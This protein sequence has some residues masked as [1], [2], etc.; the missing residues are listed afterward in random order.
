MVDRLQR[1]TLIASVSAERALSARVERCPRIA[2]LAAAGAAGALV[3][4]LDLDLV[5]VILLA[6]PPGFLAGMLDAVIRADGR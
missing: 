2:G 3:H 1:A 4:A 5:R 6:S